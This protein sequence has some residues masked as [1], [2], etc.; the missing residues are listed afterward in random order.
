LT[1]LQL[2]HVDPQTSG[3][4]SLLRAT[5]ATILPLS[6]LKCRQPGLR[7]FVGAFPLTPPP[8]LQFQISSHER[9]EREE[10]QLPVEPDHT[11]AAN[12]VSCGDDARDLSLTPSSP[13][14]FCRTRTERLPERVVAP[15][16]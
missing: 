8:R 11:T 4:A 2:L 5:G 7:S 6:A 12:S 3:A 15:T 13:M 14:S 9:Q 10:N 1:S 16:T